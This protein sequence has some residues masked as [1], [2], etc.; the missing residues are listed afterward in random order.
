MKADWPVM[1]MNESFGLQLVL[2]EKTW[3]G[4][5]VNVHGGAVAFR[6]PLGSAGVR[7]LV[8]LLYAMKRYGVKSAVTAICFG[9]GGAVALALERD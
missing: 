2:Y 8:T 6:H 7:I 3:P 5:T 4:V 1:E 9:G